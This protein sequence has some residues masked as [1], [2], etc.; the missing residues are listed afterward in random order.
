MYKRQDQDTAA[1]VA[2]QDTAVAVS[3]LVLRR[4][5]IEWA[6]KSKY[7]SFIANLVDTLPGAVAEEQVRLYQASKC[8]AV[9]PHAPQAIVVYPHLLKSRQEAARLFDTELRNAGWAPGTRL[10]RF[11]AS[12]FAGKL[13][14]SKCKNMQTLGE[15]AKALRRW[16]HLF[17]E[18]GVDEPSR[19]SGRSLHLKHG[20]A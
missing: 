16:H 17:R 6:T 8:A 2:D 15:K 1:A 11:S 13:V 9:V 3:D 20:S 10:P 12:K 5:A 18:V 19:S 7:S 4:E 14:W